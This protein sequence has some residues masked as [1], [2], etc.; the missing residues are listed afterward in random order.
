MSIIKMAVPCLFGLESV[1]SGELKKIGAANIEAS[2]GKVTFTGD[3]NMLAKANI[4]LRTAE[5]VLIVLGSFR[6]MTFEELFQG[7]LKIPRQGRCLPRKRV[8]LE[9]PV[10]QRPGLPIYHQASCREENG[11]ALSSKL[12]HRNRRCSSNSIFD[13]EKYRH[14]LSGYFRRGT[15]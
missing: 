10:G 8:V 4:Q 14:N 2:D 6:A 1:L 7:V 9:F 12:V 15:A 11:A 5:R 3:W 13:S